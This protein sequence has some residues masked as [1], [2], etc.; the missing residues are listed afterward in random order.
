MFPPLHLKG[1]VQRDFRPPVFFLLIW[2]YTCATDQ[3]TVKLFSILVKNLPCYSIFRQVNF[4]GV[5][6][7]GESIS[8]GYHTPA[9]QSSRGIIPWW[10]N[11]PGYHTLVSHSLRSIIPRWVILPG[12][13]YPLPRWVNWLAGL[14]V[15]IMFLQFPL[16]SWASQLSM[17]IWYE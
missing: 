10:V 16:A 12:V 3:W 5:S 17:Q 4:P 1:T 7:P 14:D 11:L 15:D 13:S 6:Y 9:S 2:T 8:L